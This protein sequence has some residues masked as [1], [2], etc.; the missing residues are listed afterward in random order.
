VLVGFAVSFAGSL[1]GG[2]V[3]RA[4]PHVPAPTFTE[5]WTDSIADGHLPFALSSP[6]VATLADGPAAVVGDTAG[7]IYA[8]YLAAGAGGKPTQA[9]S[10]STKGTGVDSS[11]SS[12][13]GTVYIGVGWAAQNG[14]GGYQA[15]NA[16]GTQKWFRTAGNPSTDPTKNSGVAAGMAIGTLQ[17]QTAVVAGSLGENEWMFNASSGKDQKGFPWYQ[18][19]TNF[20]TP[21]IA[22]VE[23]IAGQNQIVEGGNTSAGVSYGVTYV[24][25]GQIRILNQAGNG[26]NTAKPNTGLYC[27][28]QVDQ[29]VESSPAVGDILPGS[30]PGIVAGTSTD[31]ADRTT[32]DD[33]FTINSHCQKVWEATLDGATTSSPALADGL[34]NGDLQVIEGTTAGTVYSLNSDTGAVHWK[35]QLTGSVIGGV[36]T[37]DLGTGY[38][39]IIA[40]TTTGAYIL[41]GKTGALVATL[42]KGVGLQNSPLVTRDPNGSLGITIA[43]YSGNKVTEHG[44]IEHFELVG[45]KVTT[46][47]EAGAW[48][49]FHH[50]PQLTGNANVVTKAGPTTSHVS[51]LDVAGLPGGNA[52]A[53]DEVQGDSGRSCTSSTRE[54]ELP[55]ASASPSTTVAICAGANSRRAASSTSLR[56]VAFKAAAWRARYPGSSPMMAN[57]TRALARPA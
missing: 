46:V 42:E 49:E 18:A 15:L 3:A 22:D 27:D 33:V 19:D 52:T 21:A 56:V 47:S 50:D 7:H 48:P 45:S 24:D 14:D 28:Y 10:F 1:A 26:G 16:N 29:G 40:P 13:G 23:G 44:V 51:R 20:S 34:G 55:M 8:V 53:A 6:G 31:R 30:L 36:V 4:E 25:G 43:G 35:T 57:S 32:T 41:D 12:L 38:Q 39:D 17:A 5:T 11:P 2:G 54:S 9:Y 37:A